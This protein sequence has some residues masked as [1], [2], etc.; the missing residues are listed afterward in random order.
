MN[1]SPGQCVLCGTI[2]RVQ[3]CLKCYEKDAT[4]SRSKQSM[5]NQVAALEAQN[6]ELFVVLEHAVNWAAGYESATHIL[7]AWAADALAAITKARG[8]AAEAQ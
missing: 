7:P 4:K 6:A 1:G 8:N 3:V 2:G 5:N